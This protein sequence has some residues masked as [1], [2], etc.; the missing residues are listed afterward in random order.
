MPIYNEIFVRHRV[1]QEISL[2]RKSQEA[3]NAVNLLLKLKYTVIDPTGKY[4]TE[5]NE[6][7]TPDKKKIRK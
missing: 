5:P 3:V 7:S 1:Q 4:I 6:I 2:K